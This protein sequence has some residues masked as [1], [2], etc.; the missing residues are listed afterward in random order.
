MAVKYLAGNR[1]QGTNA[2]RTAESLP[3][4]TYTGWKELGRASGSRAVNAMLDVGSLPN[5][6]YYMVLYDSLGGSGGYTSDI[7][8]NTDVSSNYN[9]R[10]NICNASS[11]NSKPADYVPSSAENFLNADGAGSDEYK[12]GVGYYSNLASNVKLGILDNTRSGSAGAGNAPSRSHFVHKWHNSSNAIDQ[13]RL[14]NR[15]SNTSSSA[16]L[17]VLGYDPTDTNTTDFWEEL[18]PA[19]GIISESGE[20]T[21]DTGT[22]TSKKYLWLQLYSKG[23]TS[24]AMIGARFNDDGTNENTYAWN[25][26]EDGNNVWTAVSQDEGMITAHGASTPAFSNQFII[27]E[28]GQ[29]KMAIGQV[30]EQNTAGAGTSPKRMLT[31]WKWDNSA[32]VTRI[33][34][35]QMSGNFNAGSIMKVW[36]SN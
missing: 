6:R 17:V 7:R 3:S 36:G 2:E 14:L 31:S 35:F 11:A 16:N 10:Q 13:I 27:N 4:G 20:S 29:N 25:W 1:I 21:L 18:T 9:Y 24:S 30:V 26:Q 34:A 15:G 28:S 5:K 23:S 19:G 33:R 12:F 8:F 22:I 32:L